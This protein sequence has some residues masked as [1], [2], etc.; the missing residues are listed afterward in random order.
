VGHRGASAPRRRRVTV[1]TAACI[2]LDR[3]VGVPGQAWS[4]VGDVPHPAPLLLRVRH[5]TGGVAA[6]VADR[7]TQGRPKNPAKSGQLQCCASNRGRG[8]A[9]SRCHLPE[10]AAHPR[11]RAAASPAGAIDRRPHISRPRTRRHLGGSGWCH[12]QRVSRQFF[13][14][15]IAAA[16][17]LGNDQSRS[18]RKGP[19]AAECSAP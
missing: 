19:P 3:A 14:V 6:A 10:P 12:R 5:A 1:A 15:S 2:K 9:S 7:A 8:G 18:A 11:P 16:S 17:Y 4:G 13:E